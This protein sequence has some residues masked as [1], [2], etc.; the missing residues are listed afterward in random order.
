MYCKNCGAAIN[1]NDSFCNQCG[2]PIQKNGTM[3]SNLNQDPIKNNDND[4][5]N[6]TQ[7]YQNTSTGNS[8]TAKIIIIAILAIIFWLLGYGLCKLI[9]SVSDYSTIDQNNNYSQTTSTNK[10][11][12]VQDDSY[13]QTTSGTS[14]LLVN[15]TYE[16][17]TTSNSSSD[18]SN[19]IITYNETKV[20]FNVPSTL[21]II[22]K[23]SSSDLKCIEKIDDE[24]GDFVAWIG[25][26]YSSLNEY[27]K[28][29][30]DLAK[31]YKDGTMLNYND[32]Q[33]S[34]VQTMTVNGNTFTYI[35]LDYKLDSTQF[36]DAYI[37]YELDDDSVFHVEL[38]E[39]ELISSEEL[40]ELLTIT[41]SK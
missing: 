2:Q 29:V 32:V 36:K 5:N 33:I 6:S 11:S 27:I 13:S 24:Y 41:I 7:Q 4:F 1:E 40:Q 21:K 9:F 23:Y 15:D 28:N 8:N 19:Y 38:K 16:Q 20:T 22:G 37:A 34:D 10:D 14:N 39:Y 25:E 3:Q 35:T 17:T 18:E 31:S 30:Q 26:D 12:L